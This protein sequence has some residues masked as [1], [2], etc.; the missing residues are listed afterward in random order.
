MK[1]QRFY[2]KWRLALG[3]VFCST[4]LMA[5][6]LTEDQQILITSDA[7]QR[8][9]FAT[10][11]KGYLRLYHE[12]NNIIYAKEAAISAASLGDI[13][14][15]VELALLYK[16]VTKNDKDI[17]INK[18]LVDGYI[19]TG[20]IDKAISLLEKIRKEDKSLMLDSVL[21]SLYLGQKN[22]SKAFEIFDKIYNQVHDEDSLEKLVTIFFV[23]NSQQEAVD[24]LTSHLE[25]YGCSPDLCQRSF[26]TLIQLNELQVAKRVFGE[27]YEKE[28][29]VRNAQLY[30][31]VLVLLK[32]FD[33]AQQI[34]QSYPFDRRLL[35]DLYTAQK[36]F[37]LAAKQA[38]LIYN[39]QKDPKFLALEAIY[40]YEDLSAHNTLQKSDVIQIAKKLEQAIMQRKQ[41]LIKSKGDLDG[42]DAF[43]YNFLG[44]SLIEYDLDI[45]KGI[46]YVKVALKIEP[47]SIFYIDSLAWGYYKLGSCSEAKKLFFS[48]SE[49]EINSQPELK[50]HSKSIA[51]CQ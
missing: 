15:A 11:K 28:P 31:G 35:L 37:A 29:V 33:K 21:G 12:T 51:A 50:A 16:K 25:K 47:D 10:A 8:G 38:G 6:G 24:L 20:Q 5:Q 26:N 19:K 45:K 49:E 48:I 4:A 43:F 7:F 42:Q 22:Y 30:I 14:T 40:T 1:Q 13:N 3:A 39:E 46:D 36:K 32:E 17:Y 2:Q 23:Q 18:I 44:Y 41:A 34:A 27:L 9:D